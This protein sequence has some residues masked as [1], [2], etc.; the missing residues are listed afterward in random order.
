MRSVE[1]EVLEW[2]VGAGGWAEAGMVGKAG[3]RS[4]TQGCLKVAPASCCSG[5]LTLPSFPLSG[6]GS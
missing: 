5:R 6:K 1:Q 3:C 2:G 4:L